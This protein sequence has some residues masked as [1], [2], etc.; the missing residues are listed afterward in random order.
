MHNYRLT[1]E[2]FHRSGERIP[3]AVTQES[4]AIGRTNHEGPPCKEQVAH[5]DAAVCWRVWEQHRPALYRYCLRWMGGDQHEAEEALSSASLKAFYELP[6]RIHEITN[7]EY[8]LR[9]LTYTQCMD[10]H[11]KRR[12][13]VANLTRLEEGAEMH[14]SMVVPVNNQPEQVLLQQELGGQLQQALARL[15]HRLREPLLLHVVEGLPYQEI[16]SR[17]TLTPANARKRVQ[18]ARAHIRA[19]VQAYLSTNNSCQKFTN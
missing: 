17:L 14:G 6:R 8:W 15:P 18:Q 4:V 7:H 1:S 9:R 10:L 5:D 11:R 3:I 2:L 19:E 13:D 12:R 16:A